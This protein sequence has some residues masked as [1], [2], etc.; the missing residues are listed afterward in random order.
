MALT[1]KQKLFADEYLID[2]NATRAYKAA[3]PRVK[4]D[5][6]ASANG[7]RLLRN[8]KVAEYIK[9]MLEKIQSERV[10]DVQE[11]LEYLTSVMRREK[12]ESIV[13]TLTEEQSAYIMGDDG[14]TRKQTTKKEIPQIVSIPAKLSDA[15]KAAELLGKRYG[16]FKE[17]LEVSGLE[18]EKTKLDDL[19]KQMRGGDG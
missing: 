16:M 13:V 4:N 7:A 12:T 18:E 10:A 11:V 19:I 2:L 9:E 3:Y 6:V 8:A 14:K 17:K 5:S 15:N 1:E